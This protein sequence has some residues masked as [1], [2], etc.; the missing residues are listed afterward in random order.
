MTDYNKWDRVEKDAVE[1]LESDEKR[2]KEENDQACGLTDGPQGPPTA[3]AKKEKKEMDELG[4]KKLEF[5][6]NMKNKEK[7]FVDPKSGQIFQD[8]EKSDPVALKILK[9]KNKV[10]EVNGTTI[11]V[12][13]EQC[14]DSEVTLMEQIY[15]SSVE[16]TNC[17]NL[18]VRSQ[19]A[20]ATFQVDG[21]TNCTLCIQE[22]EFSQVFY[23]NCNGLK[24][25]TGGEIWELPESAT[26]SISTWNKKGWVTKAVK[27]DAESNFPILP[28]DN[29]PAT[30]DSS[31]EGGERRE[32]EE[33]ALQYKKDGNQ[34]FQASDFLQAS[35]YYTQ[36]LDILESDV[37][38]CNRSQCFLKL[39]WHDKALDDAEKAERLNPL[40]VKAYFRQGM[41]LY[42]VEKLQEAC[43]KLAEAEKLD[44]KNEQIKQALQMA[45][46]KMRKA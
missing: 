15:T 11:K 38:L 4:A 46:M 39:G 44:P 7:T 32:T 36:S 41:A 20:V 43:Q 24:I 26:Q 13:V 8:G 35:C 12:F 19:P 10:L 31:G 18:K 30:T 28:T 23:D 42:A 22:E 40:N 3:K 33:L 37:V 2:E 27:R 5:I 45:A 17:S 1:Q 29:S 34:A 16:I 25:M 9:A 6:E 21:C 14:V